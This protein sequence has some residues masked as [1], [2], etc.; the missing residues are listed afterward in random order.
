MAASFSSNET[1]YGNTHTLVSNFELEA[2]LGSV[3]EH[4]NLPLMCGVENLQ[5][6]EDV[7][8]IFLIYFLSCLF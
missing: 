5:D 4:F 6:E 8:A 3:Y 2:E 1:L 7:W